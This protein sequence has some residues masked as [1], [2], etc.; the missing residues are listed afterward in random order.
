MD[1]LDI[2]Q[3]MIV[4]KPANFWFND[5]QPSEGEQILIS[6]PANHT[7]GKRAVGGKLFVTNHRIAFAPNRIDA[8]IGGLPIE[9]PISEITSVSTDKPRFSITEV[10]SGAFRTRLAIHRQP[11]CSEF[12][13]VSTPT[14][15]ASHIQRI[16]KKAEQGRDGDAE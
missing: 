1:E 2:L 16:I 3:E 11:M 13:V 6:Y 8:Q 15:T 14:D 4:T 7:Q 12:F 10:F 5:L 9:I